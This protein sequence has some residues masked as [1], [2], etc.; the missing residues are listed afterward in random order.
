MLRHSA[1]SLGEWNDPARICT[2]FRDGK[3]LVCEGNITV[4]PGI[5]PMAF[6][7]LTFLAVA[8]L[9][10]FLGAVFGGMPRSAHS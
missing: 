5:E 8:S 4:V 3:D 10:A 7:G 1:P 9:I 2:I 6:A